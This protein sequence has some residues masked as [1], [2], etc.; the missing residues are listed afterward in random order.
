MIRRYI[1]ADAAPPAKPAVVVVPVRQ[2]PSITHLVALPFK[3]ALHTGGGIIKWAGNTV[4]NLAN[5]LP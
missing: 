1:G 3:W 2:Q 4:D 5:L